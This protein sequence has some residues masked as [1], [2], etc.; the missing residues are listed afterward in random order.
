MSKG[1]IIA[2]L[3]LSVRDP[4]LCFQAR[5]MGVCF[6]PACNNHTEKKILLILPFSVR[7]KIANEP[8]NT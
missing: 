1:A 6:V 4:K 3:T 5:N 2:T 8:D 7:P